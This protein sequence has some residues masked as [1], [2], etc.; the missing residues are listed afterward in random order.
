MWISCQGTTATNPFTVTPATG[1]NLTYQWQYSSSGNSGTWSNVTNSTPTGFSYTGSTGS[2]S[3]STLNVTIPSNAT[4]GKY[5]YQCIVSA[6]GCSTP[7]TSNAATYT[8]NALPTIT[9][10]SN[11]S[12]CYSTSANT[13]PL[14]Y[15]ATTGG[16]NLT[17]SIAWG[18]TAQ[19]ANFQAVNNATLPATPINIAVPAGAAAN[20]YTGTL[21]VS[22]GTCTSTSYP[23]SVVV[24]PTPTAVTVTPASP[25]ICSGSIQM[26]TAN[27][28]LS[29]TTGLSENFD[30]GGL[31]S[32]WNRS[33]SP[34]NNFDFFGD[35]PST[36]ELTSTGNTWSPSNHGYGGTGNCLYFYT[37]QIDAGYTGYLQT[38]AMDLSSYSSATLTFYIVNTG[39]SDVIDIYGAQS[40]N[41][42]TKINTTSYGVN[43]SWTQITLNLPSSLVGAGNTAVKLRFQG[44]SDGGGSNIGLDNVVVSGTQ[45]SSITWS[46]VTNLYTNPSSNNSIHYRF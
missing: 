29:S 10:G 33:T 38:P 21:T 32:G 12:V 18:T 9:L 39:G 19:G 23:I 13:A 8:V 46:P 7:V 1:T 37:Y 28:G 15:S 25:T 16:S 26:L 20:T 43:S 22:N 27:G 3:S 36:S 45:Q 44:T 14:S 41:T 30:A 6:P 24:N 31:P 40:G 2:G 34:H 35:F 17:Y 5:Y 11:P 4:A 42:Y